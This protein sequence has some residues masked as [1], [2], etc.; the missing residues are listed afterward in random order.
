MTADQYWYHKERFCFERNKRRKKKK[1]REKRMGKKK[2]K[3]N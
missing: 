3:Q 1:K 2:Q